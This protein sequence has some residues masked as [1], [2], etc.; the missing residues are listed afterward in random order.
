MIDLP[1]PLELTNFHT[2]LAQHQQLFQLPSRTFFLSNIHL[3]SK[4]ER[5]LVRPH[6]QPVQQQALRQF[7]HFG[8][9][10]C[11][12]YLFSLISV[13]RPVPLRQLLHQQPAPRKIPFDRIV[14]Y[15]S[16]VELLLRHQRL[17]QLQLRLPPL[18]QQKVCFSC[19]TSCCEIFC[20]MYQTVLLPTGH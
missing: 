20:L 7:S 11:I 3:R 1:F 5:S 9:N 2:E 17:P 6:L 15:V 18:L 4:T 12:R 19:V 16:L 14:N 8:N 10:H 13:H